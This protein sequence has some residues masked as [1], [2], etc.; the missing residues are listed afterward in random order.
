[1]NDH[2]SV[3]PSC[4]VI[5]MMKIGFIGF[6]RMANALAKGFVSA[7]NYIVFLQFVIFS[8]DYV[9]QECLKQ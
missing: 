3:I 8:G 6:G 7:G 1:M 4:S 2:Y 9:I 5:I